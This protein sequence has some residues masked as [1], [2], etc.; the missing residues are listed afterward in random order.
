MHEDLEALEEEHFAS[1]IG[2]AS[3]VAMI[4]SD[5]IGELRDAELIL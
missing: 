3:S 5:R 1:L 2:N 4:I